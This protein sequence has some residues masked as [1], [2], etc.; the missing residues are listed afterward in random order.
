MRLAANLAI[1]REGIN[2]AAY[3]GLAKL[4][5]S[6]VPQGMDYFWAPPPYPYDARRGQAAPGR[7]RLPQRLRRRRALSA[8]SIY[9]VAIGE[10]VVNYLQAVGHPRSPPAAWS[11]PPSSRSTARRSSAACIL[12]GSGAPGNAATRLEQY[13][14]TGGRYVYGTYPEVD[15]LFS[16]QVNEMN[17]RVRQQILHK[18]QQLIH[19]RVMFGPVIEPAF[20]NGVGPA[21]SR[22]TASA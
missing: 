15:G 13:A 2:Q 22:S 19:E 18:I 3:L 6:F 20:L 14:V 1:D 8:T 4:A 9:G 16:E 7:G 12:S 21:R 17:P 5:Y 11:A 10:P